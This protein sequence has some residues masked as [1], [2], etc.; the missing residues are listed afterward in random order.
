MFDMRGAGDWGL[1][2]E[3]HGGGAGTD[4]AK[5]EIPPTPEAISQLRVGKGDAREGRQT[6]KSRAGTRYNA[7]KRAKQSVTEVQS[8]DAELRAFQR[9]PGKGAVTEASLAL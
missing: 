5:A 3:T 8:V 7:V 2:F 1:L 6:D 4:A 9:F